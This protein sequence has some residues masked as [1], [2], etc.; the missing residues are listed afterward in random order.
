MEE[1]AQ[2]N[3][4]VTLAVIVCISNVISA[5]W[6]GIESW[7]KLTRADQREAR[8]TAQDTAISEL[9]ARVTRCE[10][11][12][13]KGDVQ[14][15][16]VRSDMTQVLKVMSAELMHFISGNDHKALRSIKDE[17]DAYMAKR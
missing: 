11:R 7:K 3:L 9:N 5:I 13:A 15:V 14:F 17:L 16:E 1:L 10:E 8:E 4:I 12:L 6:K 2:N